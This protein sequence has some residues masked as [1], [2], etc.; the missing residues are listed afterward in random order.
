MTEPDGSESDALQ[1]QVSD[2]MTRHG[3]EVAD[4][5]V[6]TSRLARRSALAVLIVVGLFTVAMLS[7]IAWLWFK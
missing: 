6:R 7:F 3:D 2:L 5:V 1:E 4:E